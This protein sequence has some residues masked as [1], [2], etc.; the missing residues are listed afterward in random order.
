MTSEWK[1]F[2]ESL[3]GSNREWSNS[4]DL[5]ALAQLQG[6]ELERAIQLLLERLSLGSPRVSRALGALG[7]PRM[8]PALEAHS[9]LATGA[10]RAATAAA[11]VNGCSDASDGDDKSPDPASPEPEDTQVTWHADI[12]P[13]VK[14]KC[15]RCHQEDGIAPFSMQEY[16]SAKP[17]A[18]AM[19]DAVEQGR[20]PPFLAQD[21]EN[22]KPRLP[23]YEDLRLSPEQ[24]TLFRRWA[25]A[26]APETPGVASV[27]IEAPS[28]SKLERED[29]VIRLPEPIVVDGS[30]DLHT[31]VVVDPGLEKDSYVVGRN[32]TAGNAKVLHHLISYVIE[33][34][35]L[36]DGTPRDKAQLEAAVREARGIGIGGRY[37]CFGG[38]AL[39]GIATTMLS[40]WAPGV[41]PNIAPSGSAQFVDKDSLV[42][43]D[44]HYHPTGEAQTDSDTNVSLM[45]TDE[46]PRLISQIVLLGNASEERKEYERG[47]S[48]LFKQ[49]GESKAEFVIPA[50][51]SDHVEEMAWTWKLNDDFEFKL[52]ATGTHMHYVGRDMRVKLE[53]AGT[54]GSDREECLIETPQWDFNWQRGYGY[55][56]QLEELP[57]IKNG[58]KIHMHCEYDN[59]MQNRFVAQALHERGMDAPV[60]VKLGEDTLDEMCLAGVGVIA[61]NL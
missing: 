35:T 45:L 41:E 3:D 32:A 10:D 52:Y 30:K 1:Q 8:R 18:S 16:A 42:L 6:A 46:R 49:P 19:A 53:H 47:I 57:V 9:P 5:T 59:T 43:L 40:G 56:A 14:E 21:T 4:I 27:R 15:A 48:E 50:D 39:S 34:G 17:W 37:D 13:I 7:D 36:P 60:E 2:I 29:V 55:D 11:L 33:P 23:W 54:T 44:I 25:K 58:D 20:M 24:K 12:A 61:P 26:G 38:T 22:C 51:V 28:A 31:C